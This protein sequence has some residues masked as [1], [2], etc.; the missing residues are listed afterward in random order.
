[1]N[2]RRN[3]LLLVLATA[4]LAIAG[5][6][7]ANDTLGR[8]WRLPAGLLLLGLA[9]EGWR[10]AHAAPSLRVDTAARWFLGRATP[11]RL[12]LQTAQARALTLQLVP[13][14]PP[15][16]ALDRG[17]HTVVVPA[18]GSGDLALTGTARRLDRFGW[19]RMPARIGGVLGLAW[20]SAQLAPGEHVQV[21]PDVLRENEPTIGV[22]WRGAQP[23]PRRGAG[24][25]VLQLRD[26]RRG[27]APRAIDWKASAR[28]GKLISRDYA[29][30]QH[31][32]I[33]VAIDVG[34]ASGLKAGETDRLALYANIAARFAQ[35]AALL[36]DSVGLLLYAHRPLAAVP[37]GRGT[38][39]VARLRDCLAGARVQ[40]SDANPVLA[41]LR[42]RGLTRQ[43]SLVIVLTGMDDPGTA[44]E[45]SA[46]ARLL[47][48][49][50]L[51][52]I[53]GVASVQAERLAT[54]AVGDAL[55][56]YQALAAQEHCAAV[57]RNVDSL[58]AL[59]AAAVLARP[60]LLEQSVLEAYLGFR[61]RRRVG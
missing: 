33:V 56:A 22:G 40:A 7:S 25:E 27:D 1:M 43:R 44:G 34:R 39:A 38:A 17:V 13:A 20:W 42:I 3:A 6:W 15:E 57:E 28:F 26:Y 24:A 21:V 46:A 10:A 58:R 45:L 53:A 18:R 11:L 48:P 35:R 47:L 61:Q 9:Y 14:A 8:L 23:A 60:E 4:L 5:Q 32:E 55:G 50:H 37:P 29:E 36:D 49:K 31:L 59:G 52:F 16:I 41:A 51:P 30:D 12:C 2:L 54:A 19:P